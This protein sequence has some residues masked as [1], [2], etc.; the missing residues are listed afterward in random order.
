MTDEKGLCCV[1]HDPVKRVTGKTGL[2]RPVCAVCS[3]R[4]R[5]CF[6]CD[7]MIGRDKA[8][9]FS[10]GRYVCPECTR[11][12]VHE[13]DVKLLTKIKQYLVWFPAM[14]VKYQIVSRETLPKRRRRTPICFGWSKPICEIHG[15]ELFI[16]SHEI[17]ILIGLPRV[18]AESVAVHE[19][20]HA[21]LHENFMPGEVSPGAEEWLCWQMAF[22]YLRSC[23]E[24]KSWRHWVVSRRDWYR[25]GRSDDFKEKTQEQIIDCLLREARKKRRK[26]WLF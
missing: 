2:G 22:L 12:A 25:F 7:A 11:S 6:A 16:L 24:K 3:R 26:A 5:N 8:L 23:K 9:R 21:W 10:D 20:F 4:H 17:E 1:C 15:N 18:L 19:F 13:L 14:P